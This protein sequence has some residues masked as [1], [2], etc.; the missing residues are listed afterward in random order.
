MAAGVTFAEQPSE[1]CEMGSCGR[2]LRSRAVRVERVGVH[3]DLG[4]SR[5]AER[6]GRV[7]LSLNPR[8]GGGGES[9]ESVAAKGR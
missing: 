5:A 7:G 9:G 1:S 3:R 6:V 2:L 8:A 4:C